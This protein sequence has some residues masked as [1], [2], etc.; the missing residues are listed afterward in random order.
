[1]ENANRV[2]IVE[3]DKA[4]ETILANI[5][6]S[7]D[8]SARVDRVS[9]AEVAALTLVQERTKGEP[10]SLV[11]ADIFLEGK[12]TGV[13]LWKIYQEFSANPFSL[14]L[15]SS[16]SVNRY[17]EAV[18][19]TRDIPAYLPKPFYVDECRHIIRRFLAN[20]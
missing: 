5:V 1:M 10:Y 7:M 20:I 13:D 3:D 16:L 6:Y 15:T 12:L 14:V 11:I 19:N 17:L 8:P 9:N 4:C 2:L 18:G